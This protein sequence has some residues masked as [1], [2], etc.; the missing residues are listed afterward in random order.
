MIPK[1][2]NQR[3]GVF[4]DAANLYHS[5][6]SIYGAKVNFA[7]VVRE[8]V[9][10]RQIVRC[11]AYV[12]E[13]ETGEERAFFEALKKSDIE[14]RTMKLQVFASG[15][16]KG[17][18]DVGLAIDAVRLSPKLDA[19]IIVSGDGDYAPLVEYLKW[20][21]GCQVEAAA[22]GRSTSAKLIE[23]ADGFLDLD[24]IPAKVLIGYRRGDEKRE[25]KAAEATVA[26]APSAPAAAAG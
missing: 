6:R 21:Q 20:N 12:V 10:E 3:V 23:V 2:K 16:K 5:A 14:L 8:A 17:N 26:E 9:G 18:W 4:I 13:S 22:F 19:A 1:H 24:A 15:A 11:V 25:R 7:A